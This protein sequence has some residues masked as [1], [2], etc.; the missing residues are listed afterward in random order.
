VG[1]GG[2][3][4]WVMWTDEVQVYVHSFN[5]HVILATTINRSSNLKFGLVCIYGDPYHCNT[6]QI[7]DKVASFVYDKST[8]SV[9]CI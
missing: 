6:S 9:M 2:L 1:K 7:W 3:G 4:L 5:F 8:M